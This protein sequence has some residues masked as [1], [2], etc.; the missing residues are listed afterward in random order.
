MSLVRVACIVGPTASGKSEVAELVAMRL[1]GEVVS[2]DSM[3]VYR[4]MDIGTAKLGP[5]QRRVPLHM[6]DVT[7]VSTT[8]SVAQFQRDARA[9]CD[10]IAAN[11]G[12]PVL[13]GGTGLYL[14]AV[15]DELEFPAG[16]LV[17]ERRA[18]YER[19]AQADGPQ[20]LYELLLARDARSAA[21]IHPNNV[22]R[23][24]RAL[25]LCDDG[26]SYA[27]RNEGLRR[28]QPHYDASL[29]ALIWP[30][31]AL[32]ARIDERVEQMFS[33]GL[34]DEVRSLDQQGLRSSQTASQ[35]IGYREV[36]QLLD[37]VLNLSEAK[38][39]VKRNTRHYAKRQLSWL[40][41]D[42]RA[43]SIDLS[44]CSPNDAASRICAE[45]ECR[46]TSTRP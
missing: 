10:K 26:Q 9:C 1:G 42:G 21:L 13:S 38:E 22:R 28:H 24:I 32:Y 46:N 23:V 15:I 30:R 8:Y 41:R 25:E 40:Q 29:W 6:V 43:S 17:D 39:L 44:I 27:T 4:G 34:V 14:D 12:V 7:D 37:G 3:Q 33:D 45:W 18:A 11:G 36:L 5:H 31:E 35:A 20:A 16:E 2:V 19:M